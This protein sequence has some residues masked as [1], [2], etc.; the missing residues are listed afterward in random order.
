MALFWPRI[1]EKNKHLRNACR[2]WQQ[3]QKQPSFGVEEIKMLQPGSIALAIG[4]FD[5][6]AGE[7]DSHAD[8]LGILLRVSG[9]KVPVAGIHF[10]KNRIRRTKDPTHWFR[11]S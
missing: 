10:S 8:V 4:A 3:F 11:Q 9:K 6:L 5:P 2:Q 7:I 1:G